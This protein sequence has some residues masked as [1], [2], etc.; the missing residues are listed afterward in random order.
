MTTS[1]KAAPG[2]TAVD[3]FL[4]AVVTHWG[5]EQSALYTADATLD[6]TVPNWR[7]SVVGAESI[8]AQYG[9]WFSHGGRLEELER[10]PCPG[11]EVI[12]Y[13]LTW[14][15]GGVPHA[16][17]HCHVLTLAPDGRIA[18]DKVWCGGRWDAARLA[19]MGAASDPG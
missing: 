6:A 16:S 9:T 17:H 12:T 7:F 1:T 5:P 13:L 19:D 14:V 18:R 2:A 4:S 15:V 10:R 11:G 3:G 8:A